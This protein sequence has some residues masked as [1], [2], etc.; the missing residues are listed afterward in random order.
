MLP[1][2]IHAASTPFDVIDDL[3]LS[4]SSS[5]ADSTDDLFIDEEAVA[6]APNTKSTPTIKVGKLTDGTR[7]LDLPTPLDLLTSLDVPT[8]PELPTIPP[9]ISVNHTV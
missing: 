9:S 7:A 6:D 1:T 2:E 8:F 5:D 4:S 3:V